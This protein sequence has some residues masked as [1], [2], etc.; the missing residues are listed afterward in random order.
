MYSVPSIFGSNF[1]DSIFEDFDQLMKS[2]RFS[3]DDSFPPLNLYM[4]SDSQ[5][6]TF[7]LALTGYKKDWLSIEIDGTTLTISADVPEENEE[8]SKKNRYIKHRIQAKSFKK[9]YKIPEGYD[10]EN[11]EVTYQDGLLTVYIPVKK[12][13][14]PAVKRLE[15]K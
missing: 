12:E 4:N 15:I 5:A 6:C 10:T 1:F 11:A 7:E 13:I 3:F 8:D 2:P 9:V 14:K